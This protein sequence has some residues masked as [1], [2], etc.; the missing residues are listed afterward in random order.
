MKKS[1]SPYSLRHH[2]SSIF[3]ILA[4]LWLTVSTPFVYE[5][6]QKLQQI[7]SKNV[8]ANSQ[9]EETGNPLNSTTEEKAPSSINLSEEYLHH[10]DHNE[11][12]WFTITNYHR[13]YSTSLY[14]AYHGE[15][16]CPPPNA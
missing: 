6:Q 16:F 5:A 3:M 2:T 8:A 11:H 15:L 12:P 10:T 9:D 13:D 4:L 14:I 1:R 7:N